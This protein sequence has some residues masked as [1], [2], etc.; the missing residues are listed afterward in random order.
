MIWLQ[1]L[2][3]L[4]GGVLIGDAE[5]GLY[6]NGYAHHQGPEWLI[7]LGIVLLGLTLPLW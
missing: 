5:R 4:L 3:V 7:G 2:A 1:L 6:K